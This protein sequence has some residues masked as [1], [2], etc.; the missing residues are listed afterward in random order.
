MQWVLFF[1]KNIKSNPQNR[2]NI[3]KDSNESSEEWVLE[4]GY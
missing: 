4:N 3:V 1:R 2:K